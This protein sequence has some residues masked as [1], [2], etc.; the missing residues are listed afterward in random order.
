MEKCWDSS[1]KAPHS[2]NENGCRGVKNAKVPKSEDKTHVTGNQC[3]HRPL[4]D[5]KGV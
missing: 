5:L 3:I 4:G 2:G 1:W